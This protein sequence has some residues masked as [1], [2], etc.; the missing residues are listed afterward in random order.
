MMLMDRRT[1]LLLD[2]HDTHVDTHDAAV[3]SKVH[4]ALRPGDVLLGDDAFGTYTHLALLLQAN[5]H[6][7]MPVHH[8]RR[9]DFTP[10]RGYVSM[11]KN[12]ES[13]SAGKPRSR[14]VKTLGKQDQIVEYFKP[15]NRPPWMDSVA[16][17]QI[18]DSILVRET[19]RTIQRNGFRPITVTIVSTL[20]DAQEY[21]AEEL[22]D[23]R[24]TRWMV[25]TNLR[26]LKITLGMQILKCKTVE[27]V[28][29]ER[30]MFL[31]VYNLLRRMMLKAARSQ[32]VNV[33]RLSF[34]D[35]LAWLRWGNLSILPILK[36][37]PLRLGRLEPRVIKRAK[38]RYP[39]MTKPRSTLRA[40][41]RAK[42]GD[43]A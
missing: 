32:S 26:H 41:L 20:L 29:K 15:I 35:T 19:R 36:I 3:A 25:E 39:H 11:K 10:G 2:C 6:A 27:G 40:Q 8:Q 17:E 33:S 13:D 34:A 37:N 21:P 5:C 38:G 24:L 42:Y 1:G 22:I 30:L 43:A 31:L 12:T 16:W 7:I 18:P 9:V 28:R 14:Q 4:G 23:V